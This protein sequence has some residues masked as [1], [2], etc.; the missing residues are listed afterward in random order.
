MLLLSLSLL[1][2]PPRL[3]LLPVPW[4]LLPLS[5]PLLLL[6]LRLLPLRLLAG[7]M[8]LSLLPSPRWLL[9]PLPC[10]LAASDALSSLL[11]GHVG[12]RGWRFWLLGWWLS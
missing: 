9:C 4:L 5:L 1:L 8:A 7:G 10:G 11:L 12:W 2:L 3:L 6:W